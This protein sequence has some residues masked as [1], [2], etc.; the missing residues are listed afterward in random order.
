M[1]QDWFD[2]IVHHGKKEEYRAITPFYL[3]R[4]WEF[5]KRITKAQ[6]IEICLKL[7]K[8]D[9]VDT[10]ME[11]YRASWK[12]KQI[13]SL[14]VGMRAESDRADFLIDRFR[15]GKAQPFWVDDDMRESNNLYFITRIGKCTYYSNDY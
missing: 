9:D 10:I 4:F 12:N 15:I 6:R 1:T 8:G 3:G 2:E 5:E 7:N 11:A 14:Y 13:L